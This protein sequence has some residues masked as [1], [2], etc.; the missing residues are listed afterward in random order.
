MPPERYVRII[1][2]Q[3]QPIVQHKI[4]QEQTTTQPKVNLLLTQGTGTKKR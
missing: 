2:E 1:H 3:P 4:I